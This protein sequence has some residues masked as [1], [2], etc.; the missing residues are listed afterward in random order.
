MQNITNF[1]DLLEDGRVLLNLKNL[2]LEERNKD[3]LNIVLACLQDSDVIVPMVEKPSAETNETVTM[4]VDLVTSSEGKLYFPMFTTESQI[5]EDYRSRFT[6]VV[7][8]AVECIRTA[9]KSEQ[10]E[11]IILDPFT[12][13][14]DMPMPL[15]EIVLKIPSTFRTVDELKNN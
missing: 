2:F 11:G 15:A 6:M 14:M 3:N 10:L 8:P 1:K 4:N 12:K 5:P 9:L 13:P 7:L